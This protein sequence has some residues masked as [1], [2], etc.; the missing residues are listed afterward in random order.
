MD[1]MIKQW[2][3]IEQV[4]NLMQNYSDVHNKSYAQV[5]LFRPDV[6]YRNPIDI[7]DGPAFMPH[8]GW[9]ANDRM[10]AGTYDNA[11]I[12]AT[13]RFA[14][15]DKA[16]RDGFLKKGLHSESYI[17][18][19]ILQQMSDQVERR[20]ICFQRVRATGIVHRDDCWDRR[21]TYALEQFWEFWWMDLVPTELRRWCYRK[22]DDGRPDIAV[23]GVR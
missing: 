3:S 23:H 9:P 11:K 2:H 12:W 7:F 8:F 1:N 5:A 13:Q 14:S 17:A 6:L 20:T 22:E 10:F 16:L 15:L 19:V 21:I 4:W 18:E